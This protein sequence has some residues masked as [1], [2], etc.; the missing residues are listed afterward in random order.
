MSSIHKNSRKNVL[1]HLLA[2]FMAVA[3]SGTL[4]ASAAD[5]IDANS[6]TYTALKSINGGATAITT[7]GGW[8]VTDITPTCTDAV[9]MRVRLHDAWTQALW[10]GRGTS[11]TKTTFTA[12]YVDGVI[13]CDRN[14][15]ASTK[16]GTAPVFDGTAD[17][18]VAADYNALTF[19]VDGVVQSATLASGDYAVGSPLMLFGSH[20][21]GANLAGSIAA[22]DVGNRASYDLYY[23]QLYSSAGTLTHNLMPAVRDG[24]GEVGLFDTVTGSFYAKADN[25]GEFASEAKTE[26]TGTPARWTGL[27]D[28]ISMSDGGNWEGGAAPQAGD[29]LD[30]SLAPPLAAIDADISGATFGKAWLGDGDGPTFSGALRVTSVSDRTRMHGAIGIADE[31][32]A[33]TWTGAAGNG[34]FADAANWSC[35]DTLGNAVSAVP[36]PTTPITLGADVP[37]NGWADA[38]FS[39]MTGP[40][41]LAGHSLT[42]PGTFFNGMTSSSRNVI[43]NGTFEADSVADGGEVSAAPKGWNGSSSVKIIRKHTTLTY[44]QRKTAS[45]YCYIPKNANI[46]QTFTLTEDAILAISLNVVNKNTLNSNGKV[47]Y[48]RSNGN[49]QIDGVQIVSWTDGDNTQRTIT[50]TVSVPAGTHIIK[51]SCTSNV[52]NA[53]DNVSLSFTPS[54]G[55]VTDTVGGGE[56]HVNV[57]EGETANNAGVDLAG[58]LKL[59][60]EGAGAFVS[61]RRTLSYDGGTEVVAGTL[62]TSEGW[63]T[64]TVNYRTFGALESTIA[65]RSGGTLLNNKSSGDFLN[66]G[67]VL[68]GGTL[69]GSV[70]GELVGANENLSLTVDAGGGIIDTAG[71]DVTVARPL[72]AVAGTSGGMRFM[73]GGSVTIASGNTYAGTTTVEIGTI[74]HI[75]AANDF[76]N[77]FAVEAPADATSE[78]LPDGIY[79]LAAIDGDGTLP[80]S[81][82]G[83]IVKPA[84]ITLR[85]STDAK[86]VL[87]IYGNPP[88]TWIGGESGSLSADANWSLG[89]V[90]TSGSCVIGNGTAANLTVGGTFA[91]DAI[92]FSADSAPVTISGADPVSGISAITNLSDETHVFEVP[93]TFAGEILVSQKAVDWSTHAQSSVRFA[94][95][96]TG[97]TFAVGTARYL[98]GA[99]SLSTADG[100]VAN[101]QGNNDR[102]GFP[103][104]SSLTVPLATDT[105]ELAVGEGTD[106]TIAGGAFTAAVV[107]T[108]A[109]LCCYNQGEYVVTNELVM[110]MPGEDR[111]LAYRKSAGAFKFEKV[112]LGNTGANKWFYFANS[113]NYY[114]NKNVW[115]GAGGLNFADGVS[116]GTAYACGRRA[117]DVAYIYPWHSD[118]TIGTKPESTRDFVIYRATHFAT[119]DEGGV[120]RTVT[121]NGIADVR[122]TLYVNG[123]GRLQVNSKGINGES[124]RIGNITVADS[125]TLAY[126]PGADLGAGAVTV[127]AGATLEVAQSGTVTIAGNLTL[128]DGANLA[129]NFTNSIKPPVLAIANGKTVTVNG[130]V[131]VKFPAGSVWPS[132]GEK[133][134]TSCGGFDA[135]GVTVALADDPPEWVKSYSVNTDGNIVIVVKPRGTTMIVR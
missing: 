125:A 123:H 23:F 131:T 116:A 117:D 46:T 126:A 43:A 66:Y 16:G 25:S 36:G 100:W 42:V 47:S 45:N 109:R 114:Q 108:T 89:F 77:T 24:D 133:V 57:P 14:S 31:L 67:I 34:T 132:G 107:R 41:N 20:T 4:P 32:S 39:G 33:A 62:S 51:I 58:H 38:D 96:V 72:L 59:V 52:G 48:W 68:D 80:S 5:W 35:L 69:T 11:G 12:F 56:L 93:V 19:T 78:S 6:V 112:T 86:S 129:F 27:G 102:W 2:G 95:G 53:I 106:T 84:D 87:C 127:N 128:A 130:A 44:S 118:Y 70:D 115:I 40:I 29:D 97:T 60:K 7:G 30:F 94:G 61:K 9:K 120:A 28:G 22:A 15:N 81:I 1:R 134:L 85:L 124:D 54:V 104:G 79:T 64:G 55:T 113:G 73:G 50:G 3:T 17:C 10:C 92:T 65:V 49:L 13:R 122:A 37:T 110:T 76:P 90:P 121:L 99:Y 21:K 71:N 75:P 119:D 103:Q 18:T 88:N 91:P 101:T 83:G 74:L 26:V 111:H 135:E 63:G 82:L 98:N 105:S 8:I